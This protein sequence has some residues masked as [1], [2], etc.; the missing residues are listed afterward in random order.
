MKKVLLFIFVSL[1]LISTSSFSQNNKFA[2]K[3]QWEIGGTISFTSMTPV[4]SG[5]TGK[6]TS[7]FRL[8]PSAGFFVVESVEL[9]LLVDFTSYSYGGGSSY[10][11]C[12]FFF[13]PAYNFRTNSISYPYV[14]GQ[15]GFTF[16][17]GGSGS[18]NDP[19]GLAWGVEGGVKL[20]VTGS[21]L[22]KIGIN[23]SQRTLNTSNSTSRNGYNTVSIVL[24]LGLFL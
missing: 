11:D 12:S 6:S 21:G 5:E 23:Y 9:G 24:G 4:S 2:K 16:Q 8:A 10:S 3:D 22:A 15:I 1:V 14:Q 20:N 19:S 7:V 13:A 18:S 17:S